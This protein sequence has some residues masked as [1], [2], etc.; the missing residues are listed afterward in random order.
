[1][2]SRLAAAVAGARYSAVK[3]FRSR[4]QILPI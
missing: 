3:K 1:M 2:G 4:M